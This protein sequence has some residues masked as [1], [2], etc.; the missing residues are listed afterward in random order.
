MEI[1][2]IDF[3][4]GE[5]GADELDVTTVL[6]H[7]PGS[8]IFDVDVGV[9]HVLASDDGL[10]IDDDGVTESWGA[11]VVDLKSRSHACNEGECNQRAKNLPSL[12]TVN[13]TSKF[14]RG[15]VGWY[16]ND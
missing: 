11:V 7:L 13:L 1:L 3:D 16:T 5:F 15:S 6:K 10:S 8:F 2:G 4:V 12:F 9:I 14:L